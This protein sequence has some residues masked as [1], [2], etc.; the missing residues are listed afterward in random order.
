M[1]NILERTFGL[2]IEMADVEKSKVLLP[3]GYSWSKDEIVHNTDGTLGRFNSQFGGEINTP[4][5]RLSSKTLLELTDLYSDLIKNGAKITRELSLQVHI[6]IGDLKIEEIKKIFYL[7]YYTA[8]YIEEICYV[9]PYSKFTI[10]AQTPTV[11]DYEKVKKTKDLESLRSVFENS[12]K[13]SFI[14]HIVNISSY[15][16]RNTV[17]FRSFFP[18]T[19]IDEV[20]NCVFFAYRFVNYALTHSEND[21]LQI[22]DTECFKKKLKLHG[23]YPNSIPPLLFFGNPLNIKDSLNAKAIYYNGEM[24]KAFIDNTPKKVSMINPALFSLEMSIAEYKEL[25]V[26]NNDELN[27]IVYL[28]ATGQLKVEYKGKASFLQ[29]F[30]SSSEEDQ[31]TCLLIFRKASKYFANNDFSKSYLSAIVE[32]IDD[33]VSK[34][35]PIVEKE[36]A[37]IRKFDYRIGTINDAFEEGGCVFFQF[38]DYS[39]N[40]TVVSALRKHSDYALKFQRKKTLY[41]GLTEN[42]PSNVE[43]TVLSRNAYLN[44]NKRAY[45][46]GVYLYS[47]A[48]V[49]D[50]RISTKKPKIVETHGF[51]E[52]PDNLVIDDIEKLVIKKVDSSLFL[53]AQERYVFKVH[54]FKRAKYCFFVY[55]DEFMLGGFGFDWTKDKKYDVWLLSD[56]CTNNKIPRLSKLILLCVKSDIVKRKLS[57]LMVEDVS[58]CYTK[59]YTK[60]PV[61][62]KYRGLFHK[63]ER[64]YGFLKYETQLGSINWSEDIVMNYVKY[65]NGVKR[66]E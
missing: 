28:I 30:N 57:R 20:V 12:S 15:F 47:S 45:I 1:I 7:L 14:R 54:K 59:V 41:Y 5:L 21:F 27:H 2:E 31:L 52:P 22:R 4:P 13:K 36:I 16:I 23:S 66:N 8:R 42:V 64:G 63:V 50:A 43:L 3:K 11:V 38:D 61:S 62:M 39:K 32:S 26:Y 33:T 53:T 58:L 9:S 34:L 19:S 18:T 17:E 6:F 24:K 44:L 29:V 65:L 51:I 40:R 37:L 25:I 48:S 46:D 35:K 56:F 60:N 10:F 49:S 55:Y